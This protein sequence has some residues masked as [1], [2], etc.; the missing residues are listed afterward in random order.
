MKLN[1]ECIRDTLL[2]IESMNYVVEN[3][4]EICF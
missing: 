2:A 4:D 3:E 1:H